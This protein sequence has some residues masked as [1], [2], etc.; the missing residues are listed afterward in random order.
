MKRICPWIFVFLL[1]AVP[2]SA[3]EIKWPVFFLRYD[4]GTE[5]EELEDEPEDEPLFDSQRHKLTFRVKEQWSNDFTTNLY[6]AVLFKL[7]NDSNDNYGYFYLNP[8]YVWDI[9]D[10]LR[11]TSEFRSKWTRYEGLDSENKSKDLT[12]LRVKTELTYKLLEQLKIIPS[13]QS[14]FDLY[15]NSEKIQQIYTAGLRFESRINPRVR[16]NA[17]YRA[18]LRAPLGSQSTVADEDKHEFG[19]NLSWDPNK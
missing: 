9:T 3:Q 19:I 16:L 14:L 18:I 7:Y 13:F 2:G 11:W 12:S 15:E 6:T 8:N 17:R 1:L 10:R 5:I 4:G